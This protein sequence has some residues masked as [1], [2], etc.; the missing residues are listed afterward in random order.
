LVYSSSLHGIIFAHALGRPAVMV[1][2]ATPEPVSKFEDY[3]L[4]VGLKMPKP[5]AS[6]NDAKFA[7]A[8]NS[9]ATLSVRAC[10]L[11]FPDLEHL[12]ARRIV[13]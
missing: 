13:L 5:L 2:P 6:I 9:P 7:V 8:P 12:R 10:D 4:G 1:L 11:Q 3:Y